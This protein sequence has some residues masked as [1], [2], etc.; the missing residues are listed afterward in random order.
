ME[1]RLKLLFIIPSLEAGGSQKVLSIILQNISKVKFDCTLCVLTA[2]GEFYEH[3]PNEVTK[4]NLQITRVRYTAFSLYRFIKKS[5]P[6]LVF[7]FDV[8]NLSLI[9]GLMS[10]FLPSKMKLI[11]RESMVLSTFIDSYKSL[12][13]LRK[14]AYKLT[15]K[16]FDSIVCQSNYMKEDLIKYFSVKAATI[17]VINNPVDTQYLKSISNVPDNPLKPDKINLISVGRIVYVKGYDLLIQALSLVKLK[18]FHLTILG[19]KTPENPGYSEY[20]MNLVKKLGLIDKVS[21]LGFTDNPYKYIKQSDL[22][23]IS[24]RTEAFSNAAIEAS[25]LGTPIIAYDSPGGMSEI[26]VEGFNGWLIE[27]GNIEKLAIAIDAKAKHQLNRKEI[28]Q[29]AKDKYDISKIIPAYEKVILDL[30]S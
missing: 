4:V 6:D 16:R 1:N 23:I 5:N 28:S 24:S 13:L 10:F 17:E 29:Y 3:I 19:E 14:T 21:F 15:F 27:D 9:M 22:L 7:V 2:T 30:L 25:A 26:V 11:T 12:K 18:N 20:V 8:N